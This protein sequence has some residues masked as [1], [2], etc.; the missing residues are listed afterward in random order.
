MDRADDADTR[1]RYRRHQR[2]RVIRDVDMKQKTVKV[3]WA[4]VSGIVVLSMIA[5]TVGVGFLY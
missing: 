3:L 2:I 1:I 4:I 5:W